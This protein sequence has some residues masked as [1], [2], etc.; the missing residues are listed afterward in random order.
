MQCNSP[1]SDFWFFQISTNVP[2]LT[3]VIARP[4]VKILSDHTSVSVTVAI[5]EMGAYVEVPSDSLTMD[6]DLLA[7]LLRDSDRNMRHLKVQ[8][9]IIKYVLHKFI[10]VSQG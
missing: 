3:C 10:K 1:D 9:N 5:L 2:H 6:L 7:Q 8:Y 4:R